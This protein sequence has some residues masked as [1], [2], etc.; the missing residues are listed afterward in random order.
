MQSCQISAIC[1]RS[2]IKCPHHCVTLI[3]AY[4]SGDQFA[5]SAAMVYMRARAILEP[6]Y[7]KGRV[8]RVTP[9]TP[10][11]QNGELNRTIFARGLPV[12][13]RRR[14]T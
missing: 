9:R 6:I 2:T 3:A 7:G 1:P 8:L 10:P 14:K 4:D 12:C 13:R 11:S 5:A